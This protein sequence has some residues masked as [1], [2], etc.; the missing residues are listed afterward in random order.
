MSEFVR[1]KDL[2][3][4]LQEVPDE[5]ATVYC[6]EEDSAYPIRLEDLHIDE[7][8]GQYYIYIG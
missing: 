1:V 4:W 5:N 6:F 3:E 7:Y 8:E 2:I